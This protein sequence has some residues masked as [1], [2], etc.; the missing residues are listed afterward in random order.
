MAKKAK[1][2]KSLPPDDG[3]LTI[4]QINLIR[5]LS[6]VQQDISMTSSLFEVKRDNKN[7]KKA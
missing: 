7:G 6:G 4:A 1:H 5:K 2:T 3:P